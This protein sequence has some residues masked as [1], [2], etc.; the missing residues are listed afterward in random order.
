MEDH[1]AEAGSR[2]EVRLRQGL[3]RK[4]PRNPESDPAD[5]P[6]HRPRRLGG[7]P[8]SARAGSCLQGCLSPFGGQGLGRKK[9]LP[10]Y[11]QPLSPGL[12]M[13]WLQC[14]PYVTGAGGS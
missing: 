2:V 5:F 12:Q 11:K 13:W 4:V 9:A 14:S 7:K 1:L 6:R 8:G 3:S 10:Q